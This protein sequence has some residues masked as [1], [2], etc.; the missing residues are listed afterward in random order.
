[1]TDH[2]KVGVAHVLSA[3]LFRELLHAVFAEQ[4]L[5]GFVGFDDLGSGLGF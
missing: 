1:M 2:V 3:C 5:P 4:A